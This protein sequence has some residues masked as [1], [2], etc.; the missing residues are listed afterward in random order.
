MTKRIFYILIFCCSIF[1]GK[2][3]E[4]EDVKQLIYRIEKN[5]SVED[6]NHLSDL[7][8][9]SNYYIKNDLQRSIELY[10]T[11][12]ILARKLKRI[13]KQIDAMNGMADAFW[14]VAKYDKAFE[15][16]YKAYKL[17][18]SIHDR[19][20]TALSLYNL[21]WLSCIDQ[22]NYKDVGY[23]FRSLGLYKDLKDD[24]GYLN[25]YNAIGLYY[26]HKFKDLG[27]KADFDSAVYYLKGG[28]DISRKSKIYR[29]ITVFNSNL[30]DLFYFVKDYNTAKFY[31]ENSLDQYRLKKDSVSIVSVNYKIALCEFALSKNREALHKMIS[32]YNVFKRS[33]QRDL[34]LDALENIAIAYYDLKEY[35]VAVS[36][37]DLYTKLKT[38]IDK[39]TYS[40]NLKGLETSRNLEKANAEMI[41]LQQSN[42]IEELK[43]KRKTYYISIL[44]GIGLIV[45]FIAYLLYRRNKLKQDSNK[46]LQAQNRIILEKTHE[47]EQSIKYAKGIQTTFLPEKEVLDELL[48]DNFIYFQPKDIVSGDFYWFKASADKK[49]ILIACADCTGHGVPGALMSMVGINIL[50]QIFSN[51]KSISPASILKNLNNEI[52]H[53]LKQNTEQNKQ[54]DGMDIS[55]VCFD[56]E[57]NKLLYSGANRSLFLI[58]NGELMEIKPTKCA[59]G[60]YTEYNAEFEQT[61]I[62]L[63]KG[64]MFVMSTD[65][66]ADQFGGKVGKKFMTRNFKS[67]VQSIHKLNKS[68]QYYQIR[69]TFDQWRG[70]FDQVDDVCVIGVKRN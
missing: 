17:A 10:T 2:A 16:Y 58:K 63:D 7:L 66:Y 56:L 44:S 39:T 5:K 69:N 21:G 33:G 48:P 46:K 70:G 1:L 19:S 27:Q 41:Q 40:N 49:K 61:E 52:K 12:E 68:E 32:S 13:D 51:H 37:Y 6:T 23:L 18:D 38:D 67:L 15:F 8:T 3:Q 34:E 9:L 57:T 26:T 62:S 4:Q 28:I 43:N 11:S 65:G 24:D 25:V 20:Q 29:K 50:Q 22:H 14:Y 60:G 30:G 54:R 45:V 36:Y 59:I 42:E 64:D 55:L 35:E 31:H 47:I 53:S